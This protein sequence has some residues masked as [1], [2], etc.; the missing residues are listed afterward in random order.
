MDK[1]ETG[2]GCLLAKVAARDHRAFAALYRRTSPKLLAI[3]QRILGNRGAAE[4]AVQEVFAKIWRDAGKF[5]ASRGNP[6]AWMS[7]M[8]RNQAIDALRKQRRTPVPMAEPPECRQVEF[9]WQQSAGI[10]ATDKIALIR[11]LSQ[12]DEERRMMLLCAY[13]EGFTR[14]ELAVRFSRPVGTVKT[15]LRASLAALRDSLIETEE[16]QGQR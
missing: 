2:L 6:M 8:T 14:E 4:D 11:G 15:F 16:P 5:E 10:D 9:A 3:A 1:G 13:C 12:L 7:T